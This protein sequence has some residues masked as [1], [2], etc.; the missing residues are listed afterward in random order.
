MPGLVN[1]M[2]EPSW[3]ASKNLALEQQSALTR[4]TDA[5]KQEVT[6]P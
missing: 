2:I 5:H 1:A 6:M 4:I 3:Q